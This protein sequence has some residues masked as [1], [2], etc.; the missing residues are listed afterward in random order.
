MRTEDYKRELIS[1][2]FAQ[3]NVVVWT[4][5]LVFAGAIGVAFS[6]PP[7]F[8]ATSGILVKSKQP[9]KSPEALEFIE[10]AEALLEFSLPRYEREGKS[11]LTVAVGC[12]GGRHR[13][14]FVAERLARW[15][16]GDRRRVNLVHRDLDGRDLAGRDLDRRA[17]PAR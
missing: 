3:K 17:D 4:M 5:I 13:S 9:E 8:S 7:T 16:A 12:T 14:V 10:K 1:I 15:L 6:W 2:L 11:Y